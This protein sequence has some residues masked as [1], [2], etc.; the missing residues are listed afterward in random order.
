M[1]ARVLDVNRSPEPFVCW[2]SAL[3]GRWSTC[4]PYTFDHPNR[5]LIFVKVSSLEDL[6]VEP[7]L[8]RGI[9][10]LAT[11]RGYALPFD[12]GLEYALR[13][14][15]PTADP[16]RR[17]GS[18]LLH[19]ALSAV[20]A[21]SL[22]EPHFLNQFCAPWDPEPG[23]ALARC[24]GHLLHVLCAGLLHVRDI[25]VFILNLK[26]IAAPLWTV[27]FWHPEVSE[28]CGRAGIMRFQQTWRQAASTSDGGSACF[29][30]SCFTRETQSCRHFLD[31][32]RQ[33]LQG[34][35]F[36]LGGDVLALFTPHSA[37]R[38]GREDRGFCHS[39]NDAAR[40]AVVAS[41]LHFVG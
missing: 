14:H 16:L 39:A 36:A 34:H 9:R 30:C 18:T 6:A 15:T 26:G 8:D 37:N 31:S 1:A 27:R 13:C 4:F 24:V 5:R 7:F 33:L 29:A 38:F 10:K 25:K 21:C 17:C 11:D 23:W 22:S 3:M 40:E 19:R 35:E 20:G 32:T 28:C 2:V 41:V 12:V